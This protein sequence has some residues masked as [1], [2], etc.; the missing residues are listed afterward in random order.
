MSL[1]SISNSTFAFIIFLIFVPA[2]CN[3]NQP[4]EKPK[5]PP[6]SIKLTKDDLASVL[7]SEIRG[8]KPRIAPEGLDMPLPESPFSF[9]TQYYLKEDDT[10]NIEIHDYLEAPELYNHYAGMWW[11]KGIPKNDSLEHSIVYNISDDVLGWKVYYKTE[12]R[13]TVF[14][15]AADRYYLIFEMFQQENA[16]FIGEIAK[17]FDYN[18]LIKK[19]RKD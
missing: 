17:E 1:P 16:Y 9:T 10:L 3:T 6:E 5:S 7:P 11:A 18:L 14:I 19:G 15:G 13:A 12:K 4:K 2:G 8:Y